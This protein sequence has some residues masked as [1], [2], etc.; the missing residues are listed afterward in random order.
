MSSK[1][2]S[3]YWNDRYRNAETGW[4]IGYASPPLTNYFDQLTDKNKRILI[5]GCGNGYEVAYLLEKGFQ[6][7]TVID[8][9]PELTA[10]LAK[11]YAPNVGKELTIITGDFFEHRGNYDIIIEQTFFCALNPS[12]R[13]QYVEKMFDLLAPGGKLVGVLFNRAFEG[14]PP[15]GGSREEYENLFAKTFSRRSIEPCYNSIPP[16]RDVELFIRMEK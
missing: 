13:T 7:I 2:D 1:L 14:G 11:K 5:P 3:Q 12:L 6:H 10:I 8:I 15:F 16:R 9:A 4:D